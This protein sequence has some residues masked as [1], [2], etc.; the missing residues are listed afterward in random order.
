[1]A[2]IEVTTD[3][4]Q[5]TIKDGIVLLD[6]WA[7]W[8]GPCR[9]FGPVFEKASEEHTDIRFGKIDT[10]AQTELANSFAV[11]SIPTLVAFRDGIRVFQQAGALRGPDLE[12]L[13]SQI[14][15]LDMDAVRE[16]VAEMKAKNA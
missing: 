8:C 2:T 5:D 3:N 15:K 10:D 9:Q 14:E 12:D 6:F 16:R 4:F 13:I 1:M 11:R 7:S